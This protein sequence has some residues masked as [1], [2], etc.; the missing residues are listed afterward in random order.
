MTQGVDSGKWQ[1]D[2][3]QPGRSGPDG[4]GRAG[5]SAPRSASPSGARNG[6][7]TRPSFARD[8][9][10]PETWDCPRCGFPAGQDQEQPA[11]PP[12]T[13]PYKTHLAYVRERR[14]DRTARRSSTRRWRSSG[15]TPE[16][17][18]AFVTGMIFGRW[19]PSFI[20]RR[21]GNSS[22]PFFTKPT[23]DKRRPA[24]ANIMPVAGEAAACRRPSGAGRA[25]RRGSPR[26]RRRCAAPVRTRGGSCTARC[27]GAGGLSSSW[28]AGK[29]QRG[30]SQSR[31]PRVAGETRDGSRARWSTRRRSAAAARTRRA[32]PRP[33]APLRPGCRG[34]RC[35]FPRRNSLRSMTSF[36][37]ACRALRACGR[38]QRLSRLTHD[39]ADEPQQADQD[40]DAVEVA[41]GDR[42]GAEGRR[43]ATAEHV[44][45]AAALALVQ[46]T[47]T[48]HQQ[49]K[50]I[51]TIENPITTAVFSSFR[52]PRCWAL[53]SRATWSRNRQILTNSSA[54]RRRRRPGRRRR[55]AA[56]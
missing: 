10:I 34:S 46:S 36:D 39:D 14:S 5:E 54:S 40:R 20:G 32:R 3:W 56:P 33:S 23:P 44:G 53:R 17:A 26:R 45:Q 4:R 50:M 22:A 43:D 52:A 12:R 8:A 42:G 30:Q 49:A 1:R 41:L 28:P 55:L 38:C 11:A 27:G 6:H 7:E 51:R 13:E 47:S 19:R 21:L 29:P 31:G 37:P 25:P 16:A 35:H 24:S 48:H 9:A 15:S 2:P 18:A